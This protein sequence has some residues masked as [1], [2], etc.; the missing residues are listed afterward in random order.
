MK[1]H[2]RLGQS[3]LR[4]WERETRGL[5]P[6]RGVVGRDLAA[7]MNAVALEG[8]KR[9]RNNLA[10]DKDWVEFTES[11]AP[12]GSGSRNGVLS[13]AGVD[14][15][16]SGLREYEPA[17]SGR[18]GRDVARTSPGT[19]SLNR[20]TR[21]R[22]RKGRIQPAARL[23]LHGM[24][25]AD[26]RR[27]VAR[28]LEKHHGDGIRLV[29]VI[30]GYGRVRATDSRREADPPMDCDRPESGILKRDFPQWVREGRLASIV[31]YC[32]QAHVSHGGPGAFYVYL[33]KPR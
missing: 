15:D 2:E 30:T 3:D 26:A 13:A 18:I 32:C 29:L 24:R 9:E 20:N 14:S 25:Y 6:A 17:R 16:N 5:K 12:L 33:K 4:A 28:F 11:V 7:G 8:G 10:Q 19:Y 23:D 21:E 1:L 22:L 31:V 27:E